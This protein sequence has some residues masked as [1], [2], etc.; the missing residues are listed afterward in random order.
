MSAEYGYIETMDG[1]LHLT[2][3]WG[4]E[5]HGVSI[6][7]TP[8]TGNKYICLSMVDVYKLKLA[9]DKVFNTTLN[10]VESE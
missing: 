5:D 7:L 6:Q 4:G 8:E 3:F 10:T 2:K 9:L 1:K